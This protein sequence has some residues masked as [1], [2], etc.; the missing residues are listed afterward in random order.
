MS[1]LWTAKV[2]DHA[3]KIAN[4]AGLLQTNSPDRIKMEDYLMIQ[5]NNLEHM[6]ALCQLIEDFLNKRQSFQ[7]AIFCAIELKNIC[8][9]N[10]KEWM[11]NQS[12]EMANFLREIKAKIF[13][14]YIRIEQKN[15]QTMLFECIEAFLEVDY[16]PR[17]WPELLD[18]IKM[19]LAKQDHGINLKVFKCLEKL[20]QKY[21]R[22]ERSDPL[23]LEIIH[24]LDNTHDMILQAIQNY[25]MG[26]MNG[27]GDTVHFLHCLRYLLQT[28]YHC[29]YQDIH[30]KVEDSITSWVQVLKGILDQKI[31]AQILN[32]AQD[33]AQARQNIFNLKGEC[34]KVILLI[35]SKYKEDFDQYLSSFTEEIWRNCLGN[36]QATEGKMITY[37]IKY[38]KSFASNEKYMELF[39]KN[40]R[41]ILVQMV[42]PNFNPIEQDFEVFENESQNF[43]ENLF[44]LTIRGV[45]PEREAIQDFVSSLGKFHANSLLPIL[46]QM[47]QSLFISSQAPLNEEQLFQRVT[48]MN[49]LIS[50][51]SY[52]CNP[53]E[54]ILSVLCPVEMVV[55]TLDRMALPI[56]SLLCNSPKQGLSVK[57]MFV[58][59]HTIRFMNMF[60]YF[61]PPDKL[62][63]TFEFIIQKNLHSNRSLACATS[64]EKSLFQW[65]TNLLELKA[66]SVEDK[67]G[68]NHQGMNF[69]QRFY[70]HP[71]IIKVKIQRG[72]FSLAPN[73]QVLGVICES[74]YTFFTDPSAEVEEQSLVLFNTCLRRLGQ[75]VLRFLEPLL[76]IYNEFF[77]KIISNK[78]LLNFGVI[79]EIFE[80]FGSLIQLSA[81]DPSSCPKILEIISKS[82]Q[83]FSKNV[84]E[85][86]SLVLQVLTVFIRAFQINVSPTLKGLPPQL[87]SNPSNDQLFEKHS[88]Q[89]IVRSCLESKNYEGEL[90]KLNQVYLHLLSQSAFMCPSLIMAEWSRISAIL[91][92][93]V[94]Q[95]MHISV[96]G[97]LRDLLIS[98]TLFPQLFQFVELYM[99]LMMSVAPGAQNIVEMQIF[100]REMNLFLMT[101]VDLHGASNLAQAFDPNQGIAT[102]RRFFLQDYFAEFLSKFAG[103]IDRKYLMLM[104]TR[105]LFEDSQQIIA[106]F[107]FD[108]FRAVLNALLGNEYRRKFDFKSLRL[109]RRDN[110]Q[111]QKYLEQKSGGLLG[112]VYTF[113]ILKRP[114]RKRILDF[115]EQ[116]KAHVGDSGQLLIQKVSGLLQTSQFNPAELLKPEYAKLFPN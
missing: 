81:S 112:K 113:R 6:L 4:L 12:A 93:L 111:F 105:F 42:I 52:S 24:V 20:T 77:T 114:Y 60:R 97:F 103:S 33:K 10:Y 109:T 39:H 31:E 68:T 71:H 5:R 44:N 51:M 66:F 45:S 100:Y 62:Y 16:Y 78:I 79:N 57:Q 9:I 37:S 53:R 63:S 8:V 106:T 59:C 17:C 35:N 82:T 1:S 26:I 11:Q 115:I 14:L 56:V 74:L 7:V 70:V 95:Q 91:L 36:N 101:F 30:P 18:L 34:V 98:K 67:R 64:F 3:Q 83:L 21:S 48:F 110:V 104:F 43:S 41:D 49:L 55:N 38:F 96:I 72:Q 15:V 87:P 29:I 99:E 80:S 40:M 84:C 107:E 90:M 73:H 46:L 89:S 88:L 58:L 54:G 92:T 32:S 108:T 85:L 61:L 13:E 19:S 23:Y 28:F 76:K 25:M 65:G 102:L 116:T 47:Q 69:Y 2:T 75:N 22:E 94:K 27:A 86:H 50:S